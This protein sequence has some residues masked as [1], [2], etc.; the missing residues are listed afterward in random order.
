MTK[1]PAASPTLAPP[2]QQVDNTAGVTHTA[3]IDSA[4][5]VDETSSGERLTSR[6]RAHLVGPVAS[7]RLWGWWG[8]VAI[9]VVGGFFRFW[10]LGRPRQLVFDET[11]YVK[12]GS[13]ML[14]YGYE[15]SVA[16]SLAKTPD[17]LFSNGT[18]D[19]WGPAADFVVHPPAGKW[20]IA[21]GQWLFGQ[22]S[23]FG[24]R[25]AVALCGTLSILMLAR[26][27]RRLFG[28]T[29]L[30]CVA[31]LLLAFEGHHFVHSRTGLLDLFVMFWALAAFGALLVDR[32]RF[33]E[34]LA[35]AAARARLT[36]GPDRL[37]EAP[38]RPAARLTGPGPRLWW[39][40]W[41]LVAGACLGACCA[42]KW[43][44]L[45]FLVV[46]GLLTVLWDVG[47]RRAAGVRGWLAAGLWRD[48]VPAFLLVVPSALAAYL[49][50]WAGWFA[51]RDGWDRQWGAQHPSEHFGFV[52]DALRGLWHY[53]QEAYRFHVKLTSPHDYE[54]NPWSW[55][56]QGRPTSFFYESKK[57]GQEGCAVADCSKAITSLGTPLLWWGATVALLVLLVVWA[58]RRDWRAGAILAGVVAGYLPWFLFQERTIFTFYA[59]A[60]VPWLVLAVTYVVGM[61][62][63]RSDA[64]PRRRAIGASVAGSYV[65]GCVVMFFFFWPIYTAQVIPYSQ[66]AD[67]MWFPSW[68]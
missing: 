43:S 30:G 4:T 6:L 20:M 34:R 2:A 17:R 26:I 14:D 59:V 42:T 46:F 15:R 13:S 39:R 22:D 38:D 25:F 52:P 47:A 33:R 1:R 68:I 56:V 49:A 48:G 35:V 27:G 18:T 24:W 54:A 10:Q 65:V 61:V 23:A 37:T 60:F 40:P 67:R 41:R 50:S 51:S 64:T 11:Y 55:V 53:H 31:G 28:S 62:L 21:G 7:S 36:G 63:G 57:L 44:G 58:G 5:G 32:D 45:W 9:A 3:G 29:L 19:V 66:W 8:P 16:P 12:Q